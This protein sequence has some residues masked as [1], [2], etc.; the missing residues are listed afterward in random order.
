MD[1]HCASR[2]PF[3][4]VAVACAPKAVNEMG[5]PC[6]VQSGELV[7]RFELVRQMRTSR[8]E[9]IILCAFPNAKRQP[10][11]RPALTQVGTCARGLKAAMALPTS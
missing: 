4:T 10:L 11:R 1:S 8:P 3:P 5:R 2:T 9:L 7:A 6:E